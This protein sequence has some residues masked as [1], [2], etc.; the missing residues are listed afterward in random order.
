MTDRT[1]KPEAAER[2]RHPPWWMMGAVQ[3]SEFYTYPLY[4]AQFAV[5]FYM[6]NSFLRMCAPSKAME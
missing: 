5:P 3:V 4:L 6:T 1:P 2:Q